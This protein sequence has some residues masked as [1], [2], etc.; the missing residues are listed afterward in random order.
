[1]S[2]SDDDQAFEALL[3]YLKRS[4]G[5]DFSGYKR[6]S[7]QR[8]VQKQMHMREVARFED[9]IDYL[10]VHPEEFVSLF[11]T[12]LINVTAFFRDA[13]AWDYLQE[14][15]LPALV[16]AKP[17]KEPIRIWSVG[18]ASGEEAYTLAMIFTE[19]LGAEAFRQRVK[20]Y[21]TD[22]DEEALSQ[23]R[24]ASYRQRDLDALPPGLQERYFEPIGDRY[25]FRADL[26]RVVIFGRHD[27]VQ[28]APISRLDLL[29][30][31]NTLMYFNAETQVRILT[32]LHFALNNSGILF[33]GKAEMLLTHTDLFTP[34]SLPH[35]IFAKVPK[36]NPRDRFLTGTN[37]TTDDAL[38]SLNASLQ[39]R[40]LAFNA[41]SSAQIVVDRDGNLALANTLARSAFGINAD[42]IGNPLQNLEVSYRPL[43]LRSRL[44]QV[45]SDRR[46]L[47]ASDIVRYL[48]D[49]TIQHLK[50]EFTLLQ[51]SG[52]QLGVSIVFTD[53]SRYH[54]LE[55]ELQRSNQ[56]LE[57][58]N[59]EL[60]SS[61]EEL[62]TTNEELQST[63]EELETTNE[64]LQSTNEELETMNEELQSTNEE[65]HAIN[66]ELSQRTREVNQANALLQSI[67]AS[68]QAGVV[69][70]GNQFNILSW[71]KQ[72][73]N[74][75]GLRSEEVEG[76]SFFNLEIGLPVDQL[77]ETIRRCI[78]GAD[79]LEL[80]I[81][82]VNRRGRSFRCRVTCNPL[83][84][85]E[86]ERQ[87]V[88][89]TM[90]EVDA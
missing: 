47:T 52:E 76:Q 80:T 20:I 61:N 18:C 14:Q 49:G 66:D 7:F 36:I 60:Q 32:R 55:T 12:V 25:T 37:Q 75:W 53:V 69:V 78:A 4:R 86:Q 17:A 28:D 77:R 45:Y 11:N 84:N 31:R 39:L 48:P 33:L 67:L 54:A 83:L 85:V 19:L 30:C 82:A 2:N 13:A 26:R 9:Y 15:I 71:N 40:E 22:V 62:E 44:E 73:E 74:L 79:P 90:E 81:D 64:E 72:T 42:S 29:V 89:L 24:Q 27:L 63:N 8:R 88:I 5:F 1:V 10:E 23:A 68:I 58:A 87:G 34:V 41:T 51:E 59:E 43:E 38:R 16:Q 6:S 46:S 57:T 35:R 65:L 3:D 50:A 56:E 70:V 21:A